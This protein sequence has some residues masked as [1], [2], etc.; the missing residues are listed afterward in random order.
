MDVQTQNP[1]ESQAQKREAPSAILPGPS[2][3]EGSEELES[4]NA[5]INKRQKISHENSGDP[6]PEHIPPPQVAVPP[7]SAASGSSGKKGDKEQ[8]GILGHAPQLL[9]VLNKQLNAQAQHAL[10]AMANGN[11]HPVPSQSKD[12]GTLAELG[13]YLS[14]PFPQ[15]QHSPPEASMLSTTSSSSPKNDKTNP[16]QKKEGS[17][18]LDTELEKACLIG[19]YDVLLNDKH[20]TKYSTGSILW[21]NAKKRERTDALASNCSR[22]L[23]QRFNRVQEIFRQSLPTNCSP[24]FWRK[25]NDSEMNESLFSSTTTKLGKV[26]GYK[27]LYIERSA[28]DAELRHNVKSFRLSKTS[29]HPSAGIQ[30][31]PLERQVAAMAS[32]TKQASAGGGGGDTTGSNHAGTSSTSPTKSIILSKDFGQRKQ[33]AEPDHSARQQCTILDLL[34]SHWNPNA[35]IVMSAGDLARCLIMNANL[36]AA[37][38]IK[39]VIKEYPQ[40]SQSS[41]DTTWAVGKKG[42][43]PL[44]NAEHLPI[45]PSPTPPAVA[46]AG[47]VVAAAT[48]ATASTDAKPPA[49]PTTPPTIPGIASPSTGAENTPSTASASASQKTNGR[50]SPLLTALSSVI[51]DWDIL[52]NDKHATKYSQ[53]SE[54]WGKAKA[55]ER[56]EL[57]RRNLVEKRARV[58]EIFEKRLLDTHN[59]NRTPTFWYK[60][61]SSDHRLAGMHLGQIA[62]RE[63]NIYRK[64]TE[65]EICKNVKSYRGTNRAGVVTAHLNLVNN[66]NAARSGPTVASK[67]AMESK[68]KMRAIETAPQT[69]ET[70]SNIPGTQ[71]QP[72][73]SKTGDKVKEVRMSTYTHPNGKSVFMESIQLVFTDDTMTERF[74]GIPET[75]GAGSQV[76]QVTFEIDDSDAIVKVEVSS[77]WG[78]HGVKFT[79]REGIVS[80]WFG[81]GCG[82]NI[83]T[84]AGLDNHELC[85]VAGCSGWLLDKLEFVFGEEKSIS[86]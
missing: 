28:K 36:T 60:M 83:S 74:G 66:N 40:A 56:S 67:T 39:R 48:A 5:T 21:L 22:S 8:L 30:N 27:G 59:L 26:D 50:S 70:K 19:K 49:K 11:N 31:I 14:R 33:D 3:G 79:T 75:A 4:G 85:G 54:L 84:Y 15:Q 16:P 78:T 44:N 82:P 57:T 80:P 45:L 34:D 25:L 71:G 63:A 58:Q 72:F 43:I 1:I 24:R 76:K 42:E 20:A 51:H 46:A 69:V 73:A 7:A 32:A 2:S 10:P 81:S 12:P 41:G 55:D 47:A 23:G 61:I 65:E 52:L 77:G 6:T 38:A 35:Q 9:E 17:F 86:V 29:L 68:V 37:A 62:G 18:S 53:G 64:A 13:N